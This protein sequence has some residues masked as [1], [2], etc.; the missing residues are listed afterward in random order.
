VFRTD[1]GYTAFVPRSQDY[2]TGMTNTAGNLATDEKQIGLQ[3]YPKKGGNTMRLEGISDT[4]GLD[5]RIE[6]Y[7]KGRSWFMLAT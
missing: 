7:L 3:F 1:V 4:H 5:D 2:R 6:A